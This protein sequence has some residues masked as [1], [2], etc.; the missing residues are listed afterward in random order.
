MKLSKEIMKNCKLQNRFVKD[1]TEE[2]RKKNVPHSKITVLLLQKNKKER[3][4]SIDEKNISD[5]KIF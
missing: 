3:F 1:S 5:N 2:N 4:L